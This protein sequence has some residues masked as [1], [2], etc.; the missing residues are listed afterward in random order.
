MVVGIQFNRTADS[1][2]VV[3][4]NN[5]SAVVVSNQFTVVV[6]MIKVIFLAFNFIKIVNK[7]NDLKIIKFPIL[8]LNFKIIIF[9][10]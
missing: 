3:A 7:K 8:F 2:F 9:I 1:P 5:P 6:R 4:I 10:N